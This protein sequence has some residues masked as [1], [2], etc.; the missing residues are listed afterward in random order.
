[1][2]DGWLD[3]GTWCCSH[4]LLNICRIMYIELIYWYFIWLFQSKTNNKYLYLVCRPQKLWVGCTLKFL[5]G[6]ALYPP[7]TSLSSVGSP[8]NLQHSGDLLTES[9]QNVTHLKIVVSH[10]IDDL[11]KIDQRIGIMG[12]GYIRSYLEY[13]ANSQALT[14]R[15]HHW[16]WCNWVF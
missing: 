7:R 12:T 3:I 10:W 9:F 8:L 15:N 5:A 1:V 16:W 13:P 14:V 4:A 6:V 11:T 2:T